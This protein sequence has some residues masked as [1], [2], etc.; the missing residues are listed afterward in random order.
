MRMDELETRYKNK[1]QVDCNGCWSWQGER[2][3]Y[4]Y[5]RAWYKGF[6]YQAHRL[7]YW[8]LVDNHFKID[9]L[10]QELD[11]TCRN[12]SCVNP[13]HMEIVNKKINLKRRV[14]QRR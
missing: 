12:R 5:G 6:R 8:M 14:Y 3:K 2:D 4:G 1:I 9:N 13:E 7:I 10:K 11:H